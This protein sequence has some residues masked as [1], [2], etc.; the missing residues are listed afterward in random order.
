MR[1]L[2][3]GLL[4]V[5]L[6]LPLSAHARMVTGNGAARVVQHSHGDILHDETV[7]VVAAY[8]D[9]I[10]THPLHRVIRLQFIRPDGGAVAYA[11]FSFA[12][13]GLDGRVEIGR[14]GATLLY[15]EVRPGDATKVFVAGES[16][17]ELTIYGGPDLLDY[18]PQATFKFTVRDGGDDEAL[19]TADDEVREIF[20]GD[21]IFFAHGDLSGLRYYTDES[22]QVYVSGDVFLVYDDGCT[23]SPDGYDD[24]YGYDSG[25]SD[26][27]YSGDSCNGDVYDDSSSDFSSSDGSCSS[28]WDDSSSDWDSG[29]S[30]WDWGGD[31][32]SDWEGDT[33][34]AG[35]RVMRAM[36]WGIRPPRWLR[37]ELA[38]AQSLLPIG[39]AFCLLIVLRIFGGRRREWRR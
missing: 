37:R 8:S 20:A 1:H 9:S 26:D 36:S 2:P 34:D 31:S 17:G 13:P 19:G 29:D 15:Y 32:D 3:L 25:N 14:D 16:A 22:D 27:S 12:A 4:L 18:E 30:D 23:G 38:R 39:V 35:G 10:S 11:V 33:Y 7:G 28:D 6:A 24:E 21:V 5:G